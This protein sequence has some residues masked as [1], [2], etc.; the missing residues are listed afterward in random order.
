[1]RRETPKTNKTVL[2]LSLD[3]GYAPSSAEGKMGYFTYSVLGEMISDRTRYFVSNLG[4]LTLEGWGYTYK[5]RRAQA[6]NI[7]CY[8][9]SRKGLSL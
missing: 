5:A 4:T 9:P 8:S 2:V 7:A 6:L 3:K 1:L